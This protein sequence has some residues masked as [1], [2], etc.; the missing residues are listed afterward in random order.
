MDKGIELM[1]DHPSND[2]FDVWKDFA[3]ITLQSYANLTGDYSLINDYLQFIISIYHLQP[4]D[5][6]KLTVKKMMDY[7]RHLV[8][9]NY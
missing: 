6:F 1:A 2:I 9:Q 5:K 7:Y 3:K 4:F 8:A